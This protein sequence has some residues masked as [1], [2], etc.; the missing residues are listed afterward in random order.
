MTRRVPRLIETDF[1][2]EEVST[3]SAAEK[4]IRQEHIS[5]LQ[6]W[7][8]RRPLGVCR[9]AIFAALCPTPLEAEASIECL[10]ILNRLVPGQMSTRTKLLEITARLARWDATRDKLLLQGAR[11]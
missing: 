11:D 4:S 1:P 8:A 7:W 3:A 5:T 9:S 10:S 2:I 6:L